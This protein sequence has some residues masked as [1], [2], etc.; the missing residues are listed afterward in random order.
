MKPEQLSEN[1]IEVTFTWTNG[2][3]LVVPYDIVKTDERRAMGRQCAVHLTTVGNTVHSRALTAVEKPSL[4]RKA[5]Q[6]NQTK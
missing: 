2:K 1:V 3:T 4:Y 5:L 6:Q